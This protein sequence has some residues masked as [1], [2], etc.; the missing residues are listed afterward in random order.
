M[1]KMIL[2]TA[3]VFLL[4]ACAP[5]NSEKVAPENTPQPGEIPEIATSPPQATFIRPG[6]EPGTYWITNTSSAVPLYTQI[7]QPTNTD[8]SPSP[9]LILIPGG[10]GA[11]DRNKAQRLADAGFTV[12]FFDPDGRGQSPG[13]EDYNGT[14]HQDG[15]ASVV[16]A[17]A[18]LPE[19]DE[20]RLGM[21]S[22]SYGVTMAS[23]A[24]ARHPDLPILFYIDWE[25]PVNRFYTTVGCTG[26]TV[27]I[28]WQPCDDNEWWAE[29][30]AL[31]FISDLQIPYQR[32]QSEKDHVQ[33]TNNH[34]IEIV[35]AAVEGGV[36]WVRLNDYP[37][38]QTYD[39]DNQPAMYA[40]GESKDTEALIAR[41]ALE[42]FEIL[43]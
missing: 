15:L 6:D 8:G 3:L 29:R 20:T 40:E 23:G 9:A 21:V 34:A 12:I 32:L 7:L 37:P 24:L 17:V 19:V 43:K 4:T 42:I 31:T 22:F 35:N 2:L 41:H 11:I 36:P 16:R 1:K 30:E 14:I 13:M 18:A 33:P 38:N 27:R 10:T 5:S 26:N 25:G 28:E 39:I